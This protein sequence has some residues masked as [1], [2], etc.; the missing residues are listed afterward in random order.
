MF[1]FLSI[2]QCSLDPN[3]PKRQ[4]KGHGLKIFLCS[5]I[6]LLYLLLSDQERN[7]N[8]TKKVSNYSVSIENS[9][10]MAT[11]LSVSAELMTQSTINAGNVKFLYFPFPKSH[12]SCHCSLRRWVAH[13][14]CT[15]MYLW[16]HGSSKSFSIP[17]WNRL[18]YIEFCCKSCLRVSSV[19]WRW[20]QNDLT[21]PYKNKNIQAPKLI[22]VFT[23]VG[24]E[25][26]SQDW[27]VSWIRKQYF[28][29]TSI[30]TC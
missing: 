18:W 12:S 6:I 17:S 13:G 9:R 2:K 24:D 3:H 1:W 22:F 26:I 30:L 11:P 28:K 19:I 27:K 23:T 8:F 25:F 21:W 15:K 4:S 14:Y 7:Q 29:K 5:V 16:L 20:N 10:K